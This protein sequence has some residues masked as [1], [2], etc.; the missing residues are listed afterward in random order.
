MQ[1]N[2][3]LRGTKQSASL[4]HGNRPRQRS[5]ICHCDERSN[6][7]L[8]IMKT[9]AHQHLRFCHC[10]ERSN[11][12]HSIMETAPSQYTWSV[13]AR[14]EAIYLSRSRKPSQTKTLFR[15]CSSSSTNCRIKLV[16]NFGQIMA[17][18]LGFPWISPFRSNN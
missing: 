18:R 1:L 5:L 12:P 2:L 15:L 4:D 17:Y 7:A 6:L 11:L 3:S 9:A 16:N 14:N 8:S 10:E 13:I